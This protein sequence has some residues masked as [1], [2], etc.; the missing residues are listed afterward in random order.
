MRKELVGALASSAVALAFVAAG[1]A[2]DG[3]DARPAA[4]HERTAPS[5]DFPGPVVV[6]A[7]PEGSR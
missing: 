7:S 6:P 2:M 3:A 5:G 4:G 1:M